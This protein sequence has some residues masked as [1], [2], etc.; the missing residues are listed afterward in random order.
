MTEKDRFFKNVL[1]DII[2]RIIL[3]WI[4]NRSRQNVFESH[5]KWSTLQWNH[6]RTNDFIEELF[7]MEQTNMSLNWKDNSKFK[8]DYK[9]TVRITKKTF[10]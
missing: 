3:E 1:D 8:E 6:T 2:K 10:Y 5:V 7:S 9:G 4:K